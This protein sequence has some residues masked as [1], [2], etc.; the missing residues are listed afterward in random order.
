VHAGSALLIPDRL[1]SS[2]IGVARDLLAT[3]GILKLLVYQAL[4]V[5]LCPRCSLTIEQVRELPQWRCALNLARTQ[6]WL[7]N[8]INTIEEKINTS[9]QY[10][11]FRNDQACSACA[12]VISNLRGTSGRTVIAEMIDPVHEPAFLEGIKNQDGI[13]LYHW[14]RE[15]TQRA[16]RLAEPEQQSAEQIAI[17][18]MTQGILDPREVQA[19]FGTFDTSISSRGGPA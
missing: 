2:F 11:R 10:L 4:M 16:L 13:G 5:K 12:H 9:R 17:Y 14:F 19:R 8:W 6:A 7:D 1:A 18:K 3:P 15:R